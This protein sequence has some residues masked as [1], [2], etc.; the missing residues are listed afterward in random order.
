[1]TGK[2]RTPAAD[3]LLDEYMSEL[4]SES[5]RVWFHRVVAQLLYLAKRVRWECLPA[6]SYM[7][8]HVQRCTVRDV[9]K[10]H[11]LVRL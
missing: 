8:G 7:A 2:A 9:E 6:V 1:V 10:L 3:P 11:R 4:V 5:V